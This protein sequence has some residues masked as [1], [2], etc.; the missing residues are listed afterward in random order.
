MREALQEDVVVVELE[1]LGLGLVEVVL[2]FGH[3][4]VAPPPVGWH[5]ALLVSDIQ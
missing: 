1:G 4:Y 2:L 5:V 3:V